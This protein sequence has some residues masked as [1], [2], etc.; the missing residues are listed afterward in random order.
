MSGLDTSHHLAR[1]GLIPLSPPV[2]TNAGVVQMVR[3]GR[4][5]LVLKI[6]THSDEVSQAAVLAHYAG[7][8]AVRLVDQDAPAMLLERAWPGTPLSSLV[9]DGRDAE[10]TELIAAVI[11]EL[12]C[13]PPP[14]GH[15]TVEDWGLG[16][17]RVRDR[18]LAAGADPA[19]IDRGRGVYRDLSG[20]QGPRFLLHGDLH[21]D[22]VLLDERRGWL[23]IDPKG[24]V[25]E[26]A[27]ETS[28]MLRNPGKDPSLYAERGIIDRRV[29][30]LSERLGLERRRI[31]GWCFARS[32]LSALWSIED[33]WDATPAWRVA[34][35]S[36]PTL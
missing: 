16:F 27:F 32:V 31:V 13:I 21:H 35:A 6:V 5:R 34:L 20:S 8:G 2:A 15:R 24:V 28:S 30:Q 19:L 14:A 23:A 4:Q 22:N 1:W 36:L 9:S 10:A 33:G 26:L 25:G 12:N 3:R 11:L 18:A 7:R 29:G 17:D